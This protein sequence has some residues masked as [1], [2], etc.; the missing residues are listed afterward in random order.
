MQEDKYYEVSLKNILDILANRIKT[1]IIVTIVGASC[2]LIYSLSLNKV[3]VSESI[4]VVAERKSFADSSGSIGLMGMISPGFKSSSGSNTLLHLRSRTFFNSL[5]ENKEFLPE[6]LAYKTYDDSQKKLY[7]DSAKYDKKNEV[8]VNGKP[9][10]EDAYEIFINNHFVVYQHLTDEFIT[11][12][13]KH[14]SPEI[15]VKWNNMILD[16]INKF[17]KE[18]AIK[19]SNAAITYY[20]NELEKANTVYVKEA[21][22]LNITKELNELATSQV[23]EE[24]AL[25]IIDRP[26]YPNRASEPSRTMFVILGTTLTFF[27]SSLTIIFREIFKK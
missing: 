5:L 15:A 3:Y 18:K 21:L 24:Y 1:I 12:R 22:S 16:K 23:N 27:L 17:E 13:T 10:F 25:E 8:W 6:L 11:I 26:F 9:L 7:F 20:N 4:S 2:S 19:K 14:I